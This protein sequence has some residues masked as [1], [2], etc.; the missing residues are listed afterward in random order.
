MAIAACK[1]YVKVPLL[2]AGIALLLQYILNKFFYPEIALKSAKIRL[3]GKI[4]EIDL[5]ELSQPLIFI[6][7]KKRVDVV[8]H[9]STPADC[10]IKTKLATLSNLKD[11]RQISE[12]INNGTIVILGDIQVVQHWSALLDAAQWD[13]AHYLAPYVGDIAS[14]GISC[15][16]KK[17][18]IKVNKLLNQQKNYFKDVLLEEWQIFPNTLGILSSANKINRIVEDV[19]KLEQRLIKLEEKYE[20][21]RN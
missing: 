6:F 4:L 1:S 11:K 12:M 3:I 9:C 2:H 13:L 18:L 20:V 5:K 21:R 16:V 14:E 10:V 7:S 8:N 19:T 15:I 17:V